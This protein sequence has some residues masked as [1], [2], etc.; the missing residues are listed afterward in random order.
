MPLTVTVKNSQGETL[1]TQT[2]VKR[3]GQSVSMV[4]GRAFLPLPQVS[5]DAYLVV[6]AAAHPSQPE[7]TFIIPAYNAERFIGEAIDSCLSQSVRNVD[8]IVIDDGSTDRTAEIALQRARA[9]GRVTVLRQPNY[10]VSA[11]RNRA[12]ERATAPVT[13][14]LDADDIAPPD[15]AEF[16]LQEIEAHDVDLLYGQEEEFSDDLGLRTL[17]GNIRL[18]HPECIITGC[19]FRT[20]TVAA[21]RSLQEEHGVW[22]DEE[23]AGGEDRD[24]MIAALSAGA[25]VRCSD[26]VLLWRR[27]H[28]DNLRNKLDWKL[29]HARVRQK[30]A[31][32]LRNYTSTAV[33]TSPDMAER[34]EVARAAARAIAAESAR[35]GTVQLKSSNEPKPEEANMTIAEIDATKSA[36]IINETVRATAADVIILTRV[37]LAAGGG[38]A[39]A[40]AL[41]DPSVGA[42]GPLV[43]GSTKALQRKRP[44]E[45]YARARVGLD[46][47]CIAV[48]RETLLAVGG[49]DARFD[50]GGQA[51][52]LCARL[53]QAHYRLLVNQAVTVQADKAAPMD[54]QALSAFRQKWNAAPDEVGEK[55]RDPQVT[56]VVVGAA[57][58]EL[59]RS[60]AACRRAQVSVE[61]VAVGAKGI[62]EWTRPDGDALLSR[63]AFNGGIGAAFNGGIRRG[64]GNAVV[65][66]AAGDE[67]CPEWLEGLAAL[68]E[69]HSVIVGRTSGVSGGQAAAVAARRDVFMREGMWFDADVPDPVTRFLSDAQAKG[70]AVEKVERTA[71]YVPLRFGDKAF[72]LHDGM[73]TVFLAGCGFSVTGGGQRP[74][75]LA[76][77]LAERGPSIHLHELEEPEVRD[78]VILGS[79]PAHVTSIAQAFRDTQGVVLYG[80]ANYRERS[81]EFA[82]WPK[83]FDYC[84]DWEEFFKAGHLQF[85]SETDFKRAVTE[86]DL[87]SCSAASLEARAKELGA[88]HTV[89]ARNAGPPKPFVSKLKGDPPNFL[90]GS[91]NVIFLGS[92]WG[93]WLDWV[94]LEKLAKD[95]LDADGVI[96]IVGSR[97]NN[98]I[99][100]MPNVV[101]HGELPLP[102]AM[103][104]VVASDVGIVPFCRHKI[105]H[106][107]DPVKLYDYIA[108]GC[109][110]V[111][112]DVM[113]E[114]KRREYCYATA[115]ANMM[116][117]VQKAIKAKP[118]TEAEVAKF[119]AANSWQVRA[120]TILDA[121]E[122]LR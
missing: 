46:G 111:G 91:V 4:A 108:G 109:R 3:D 10:G 5:S 29:I 27:R 69:K 75:Q 38:E 80:L 74:T 84:D 92:T 89:I 22:F 121:A 51:E 94:A 6:A 56:V 15:R 71:A 45:G 25:R 57:I 30:H 37:P 1:Q 85:W 107:V 70:M 95:L 118:L 87:V 101:W 98:K 114:M 35:A 23:L 50:R 60:E 36:D 16:S 21:R 33:T 65:C 97:Y 19:G 7:A 122:A 41:A 102:E 44:A 104:Y 48:R 82:D 88:K 62:V 39:L 53:V 8:V 72:R 117:G 113:D 64:L 20:S 40:E 47:A 76:R 52:D 86:C 26:R 18:P 90:R 32:F 110:V 66:I 115:P 13:I 49:L 11:A 24:L 2:R 106:A 103:E 31:E 73:P 120:Q 67:L 28:E 17:T 12:L 59:R 83:V 105:C 78:G 58:D 68:L 14:W 93:V 34:I 99:P 96:N 77:A 81:E 54:K 112:T 43:R 100:I 55:W 42:V 61:V 79:Q 116:E 63:P 119:C 9:T